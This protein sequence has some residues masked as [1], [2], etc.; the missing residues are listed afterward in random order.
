MQLQ[1]VRSATFPIHSSTA[2]PMEHVGNWFAPHNYSISLSEELLCWL[3]ILRPILYPD[4]PWAHRR[5]FI[6]L[7]E[8][9][10]TVQDHCTQEVIIFGAFI[11]YNIVSLSRCQIRLN[12]LILLYGCLT[13]LSLFGQ[14]ESSFQ[15]FQLL[16]LQ[17]MVSVIEIFPASFSSDWQFNLTLWEENN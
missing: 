7:S 5:Q 4:D 14:I 12:I 3:E 13:C 1:V 17:D 9:H 16:P 2:H 11:T 10:L 6:N 8:E 15:T